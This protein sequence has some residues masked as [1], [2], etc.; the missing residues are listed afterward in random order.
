MAGSNLLSLRR[1]ELELDISGLRSDAYA[2]SAFAAV[3]AFAAKIEAQFAAT[4]CAPRRVVVR[5]VPSE[6]LVAALAAPDAWRLEV[7]WDPEVVGV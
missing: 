4:G 7:E 3:E 1:T 2:S 5:P 6:S